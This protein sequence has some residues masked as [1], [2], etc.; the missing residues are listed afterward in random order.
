MREDEL[1]VLGTPQ[2]NRK[3]TKLI[4]AIVVLIAM[5]IGA[6]AYWALSPKQPEKIRTGKKMGDPTIVP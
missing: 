3:H 4:I 6:G 5:V 1:Q 2:N